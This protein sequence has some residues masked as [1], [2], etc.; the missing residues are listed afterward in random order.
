MFLCCAVCCTAAGAAPP[1]N[2]P[3][4][5]QASK[6]LAD[7]A[8]PED[9]ARTFFFAMMAGDEATLK[10]ATLPAD[11]FESLLRGQHVPPEKM[12]QFREQMTPRMTYRRLQPGDRFTLPGNRVITIHPEAVTPDRVVLVQE[13]APIPTDV[14]RVKGVWMVDARPVIAGRRA[15]D[16]ARKRAG[17]TPGSE[18]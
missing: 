1:E 13:G 11:G 6:P 2:R 10:R 7:Q 9:A 12:A 16:S 17:K 18:K 14:Y 4:P 3:A 5:K 8:T 15:T